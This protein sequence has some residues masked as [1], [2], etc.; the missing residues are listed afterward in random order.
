MVHCIQSGP[1]QFTFTD[2][3]H[4]NLLVF[5]KLPT[6]S[7]ADVLIAAN[8]LINE[9]RCDQRAPEP[10]PIEAATVAAEAPAPAKPA[11]KGKG[12]S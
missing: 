2:D 7:D 5:K 3:R 9:I 11:K 8:G 6:Q 10:A 4:R 1:D 12:G